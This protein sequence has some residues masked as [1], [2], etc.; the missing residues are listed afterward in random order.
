MTLFNGGGERND[1][2]VKASVILGLVSLALGGGAGLLQLVTRTPYWPDL[3]NPN[4]T[5][6]T[7]LTA[8]GVLLALV[9]TTYYIYALS[10]LVM[11]R[12]LK[13]K[14]SSRVLM[15]SL[16]IT[17]LGVALAAIAIIAGWAKV[18]YTFYPPMR[19]HV[20]FYVG[21]ALLV[22][23]AWI[24]MFEVFRV[25]LKWRRQNPGVSIPVPTFGILTTW[26]IWLVSSP[27]VAA[28]VVFLLIPMS[29]FGMA[30]DVLLART[31]FWWFGHPV[32]YFWLVP[33]VALWYYLI[34][35]ITGVPL[36]SER[37]AKVAFLL[38]IVASTPV[39][40]HHQFTDPGVSPVY[41][42]IHTVVTMVVATPSML[43]AFN[44]LATL[45]R[46][47]RA[48][49][50]RGLIGWLFKLPWSNPVFAGVIMAIILFGNGGVTGIINASYQLNTVV[51]N[52]VFV[53]GHFH[54]TVGGATALTFITVTYAI[55]REIFGK[56]LAFP[57]LALAVPYLWAVGQYI[58]SIGYY[59]A[60]VAGSPRR[61]SDLLYGG[62]APSIWIPWMQI[63]AIGGLI[64]WTAGL[65]FF[66]VLVASFLGRGG[67]SRS[68][69]GSE[70]KILD[71]NTPKR[72]NDGATDLILDNLRFW[73][74]VAVALIVIGYA[75]PLIEIFS[76]GLAP[77]PPVATG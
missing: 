49:G 62:D 38:F 72:K 35:R 12:E 34:P 42:F 5:Y 23:G 19:G 46:A 40:L 30:V 48:R 2:F 6:Y 37:M 57:K 3:V 71:F 64:F 53:V 44:L 76:R 32:V 28:E 50:G 54:T 7:M 39:G 41:K 77:A 65:I 51:H 8:H 61:T 70:E 55:I 10:V 16:T 60:G 11:E 31:L 67:A 66:I 73:L 20:F 56:S 29:A 52:T 26:I 45:E 27:P 25:F 24:F 63:A 58:F 4:N 33:A 75:P 36:F 21:A 69:S 13:V 14:F 43:T 18:L 74:I 17:T 1:W 22:I 15:A 9:F 68:G 59:V 47:G